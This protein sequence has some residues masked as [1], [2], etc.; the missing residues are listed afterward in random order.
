M[1]QYETSSTGN[2]ENNSADVI[3]ADIELRP[4]ASACSICGLVD[5]QCQ[6]FPLIEVFNN[7]EKWN[8]AMRFHRNAGDE[9][10]WFPMADALRMQSKL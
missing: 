8:D 3:E 4:H 7:F 1:S 9:L 2:Q 6:D 10:W 5:L